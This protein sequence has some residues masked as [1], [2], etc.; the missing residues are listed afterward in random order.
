MTSFVPLED[1]A[2]F[3]LTGSN[4]NLVANFTS[5]LDSVLIKYYASENSNVGFMMGV[6]NLGP[7]E[8]RW[9]LGQ[10]QTSTQSTYDLS[11]HNGNVGIGKT[12][13][14][15]SKL[16]VIGDIRLTGDIITDPS[17][18]RAIRF[19]DGNVGIGTSPTTHFEVQGNSRIS[20]SLVVSNSITASNVT[21][22]SYL[23][24]SD[25]IVTSN[26]QVL[27]EQFT[28]D[29]VHASNLTIDNLDAPGPA[30]RVYQKT[31]QNQ[32]VIASF[33]DF[34][35]NPTV[36]I[37]I[38]GDG[39]NVGINTSQ[40]YHPLHVVGNIVTTNTFRSLVTTGTSPLNVASRTLVANLNAELLSGEN[41][42]YF[43]NATNLSAGTLNVNRLPTSGVTSNSY[44]TSSFIP[45]ITV[46]HT[47]RITS[48]SNATVNIQANS[49]AGLAT[50][51]TSGDYNDLSNRT[52]V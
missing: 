23:T 46:D 7:S 33:H 1:D 52:F 3:S 42:T 4:Q 11:I 2:S 6:S 24:V 9:N 30:L 48:A 50:V 12:S 38:V 13:L 35:V 15:Q 20:D 41:A 27:G 16:D 25:T 45:I 40:A 36:P 43:L 49:V 37:M 34:D 10:L 31:V 32:G 21:I 8:P 5:T 22:H 18:T 44:G 47:G 26:I 28:I 39:G 19:T 14:P 17:S 29:S 51:A